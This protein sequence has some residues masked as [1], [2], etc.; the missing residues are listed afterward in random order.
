MDVVNA[1]LIE[2]VIS[3]KLMRNIKRCARSLTRTKSIE[4]SYGAA[5]IGHISQS[6]HRPSDGSLALLQG[7]EEDWRPSIEPTTRRRA[8][9]PPVRPWHELCEE[10]PTEPD[11]LGI[12]YHV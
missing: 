5:R 11:S 1:K 9:C 2:Q 8:T 12:T 6:Q 10:A 7:R 3:P 4:L